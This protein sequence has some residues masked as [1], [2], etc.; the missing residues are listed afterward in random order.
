MEKIIIRRELDV[1]TQASWSVIPPLLQRI[2][3]S[4]GVAH[5]G[6]LDYQLA[7]LLPFTGLKGIEQAAML[8]SDAIVAQKRLLIIGDYDADGAT[9]TALAVRALRL[10][11]AEQVDFLV[12]NRFEYG[13][14]LTPE[15]VEVA[16]SEYHPQVI[17]TV[18]NG[19]AS[20]QGVAR[21]NE[22][23]IN[24][25]ITDHHLP[26]HEIPEASAIVNPNQADDTFA[27]KHL[28]GVGVIF[29]V[30][31]AVRQQLRQREWFSSS[32]RP[33]PNMAS[34]LDLVALGTVADVVPLDHNNRILV[35]NGLERIRNGK[36]S[37]G[38]SALLHVAKC[39]A[40]RAVASDLGFFVGP[41]LNAAGRLDD[42]SLGIMCL[43]S[44]DPNKA[45]EIAHAL[46][47][48]NQERRTIEAGMQQQALQI[49]A[50]LTLGDEQ[51]LNIPVGLCLYDTTWHQ[52]VIGIVAARIKEKTHRPVICFSDADDDYIKGSARSIP[53]VHIR[54]VLE[55]IATQHPGLITKFGGHAMA[56]GLTKILKH[57]TP[58]LSRACK[59]W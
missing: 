38:I 49:V 52:G 29:Y 58:R 14:G 6:A 44:D 1:T 37:P 25:V 13:Y 27:S 51:T 45:Q 48:L 31:L 41:R 8:L 11:G 26:G 47:E 39:N 35:K 30:M 43:L 2:Y 17:I 34:L 20:Y 28:A 15:I 22:L 7:S 24:V 12:P 32:Q 5:P 3:Q 9:S 23:G 21:A 59:Q 4:R 42:M 40:K 46:D 19:I 16:S 56:A 33:E 55:S 57:L 18:D 10:L 50:Q 53:G 36:C 54:D